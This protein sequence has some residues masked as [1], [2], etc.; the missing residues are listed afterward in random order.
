[1]SATILNLHVTRCKCAGIYFTACSK[2]TRERD[3]GQ[4]PC[5][6]SQ[7]WLRGDATAFD[8][9][10]PT[11][12][13]MSGGGLGIDGPVAAGGG[14]V[15]GSGGVIGVAGWSRPVALAVLRSWTAKSSANI[16]Q[17]DASIPGRTVW[18][19]LS[20]FEL[21]APR[22]HKSLAAANRKAA[23]SVGQ[24]WQ[25]SD[26]SV[27]GSVCSARS[28]RGCGNGCFRQDSPGSCPQ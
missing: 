28:I 15:N 23:L 25:D 3:V 2:R 24:C 13:A 20:A 8:V 14:T 22:R 1:M 17:L 7:V 6:P 19:V 21:L 5:L 26:C 11:G 18:P 27:S 10:L 4:Q 16:R 9:L 12:E